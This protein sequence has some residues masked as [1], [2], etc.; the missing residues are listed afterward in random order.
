MSTATFNSANVEETLRLLNEEIKAKVEAGAKIPTMPQHK[1]RD[2]PDLIRRL[3][4]AIPPDQ[5][6]LLHELQEYSNMASCIGPFVVKAGY[7][8]DLPLQVMRQHIATITQQYGIPILNTRPWTIHILWHRHV[9]EIY[10]SLR[11]DAQDVKCP[12]ECTSPSIDDV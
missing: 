4:T 5:K 6:S 2:I 3:M 10:H 11:Y 7:T 12:Y 8:R 1:W 9:V